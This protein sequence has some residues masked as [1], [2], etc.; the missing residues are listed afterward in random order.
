MR[1]WPIADA[2]ITIKKEEFAWIMN[3]DRIFAKELELREIGHIK[4]VC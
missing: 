2:I 1:Q 3:I 4:I